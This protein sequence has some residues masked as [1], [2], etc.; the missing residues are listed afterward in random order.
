MIISN[1]TTNYRPTLK[2]GDILFVEFVNV[3]L[4]IQQTL[5]MPSMEI[6]IKEH[7]QMERSTLEQV[8]EQFTVLKKQKTPNG[9]YE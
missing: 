6:N 2:I 9:F 5:W 1:N 4:K 7:T 8:Q 3:W